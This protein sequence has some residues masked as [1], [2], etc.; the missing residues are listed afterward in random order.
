MVIAPE[1]PI[2]TKY[3]D[4]ISNINTVKE[5]QEKASK[6]TEFERTQL[7][8]DKTGVKIEGITAI[9]PVNKKEI[10]IY[11]SDYVMMNYGT[12]AITINVTPNN[13]S[14]LVVYILKVS[15]TSFNLKSTNAPVLLPI[16]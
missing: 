12:G 15:S 2:I 7:I 3:K 16:Q 11:I 1:H 5:Y 9:N 8:K 14:H 10:P 6:K 13:V 4:R